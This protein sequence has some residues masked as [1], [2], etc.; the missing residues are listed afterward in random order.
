MDTYRIVDYTGIHLAE[1]TFHSRLNESS[2]PVYL[3]GIC[4][5]L[6]AWGYALVE[7]KKVELSELGEL[8]TD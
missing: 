2:H 6:E 3:Q 8:I 4:E 1:V 7:A 5:S